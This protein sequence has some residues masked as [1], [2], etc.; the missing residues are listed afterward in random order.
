MLVEWRLAIIT[1][2]LR[3]FLLT[4]SVNINDGRRS[5]SFGL[6]F[7]HNRFFVN[8][9][10]QTHISAVKAET[11]LCI[12]VGKVSDCVIGDTQGLRNAAET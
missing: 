12:G 11:E 8:R 10:A 2:C 5:R 3:I 1:D 9:V 4:E 6:L 7:L